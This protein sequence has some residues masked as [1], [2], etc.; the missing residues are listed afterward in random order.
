VSIP[1]D[2]FQDGRFVPDRLVKHITDNLAGYP[3][4][5]P[6]TDEGGDTTWRYHEGLG[7]FRSDGGGFIKRMADE[8]LKNRTKLNYV[9]EVLGIARIRTYMPR[10]Q[11]DEEP[12]LIILRNGVYH[13]DTGK[14]TDHSSLH[15]AKSALPVTYNPDAKCPL[16]LKFLERV[17]PTYMELLQEWT[18]YHLLKDQRHQRFVILLGDRDNGKSTY[19]HVLTSLLGPENVS[20]QSLYKLTSSRFAVAELYGKLANIAADIGPDEIKYTGALKIATGEDMGSSEKK[21]KDPFDFMSHAKLTFSCNQLPKTPDETGA[22][23]K[24]HL[25]LKFNVTIPLEEQDKTLKKKLITPEELSGILNWAL[26]GLHR[27]L[28]RGHFNEPTTIEE[29]KIQY[30]RLSNPVA[31]FA[32]DCIIEDHEEWETKG[33]IYKAFV[34]HCKTHGFVSPSD[35]LFFK[36]LKKHAY[37]R[38]GQKT[39]DKQRTTVLLGIKLMG[40]ARGAPPARGSSPKETLVYYNGGIGP[41]APHA[42]LA[43]SSETDSPPD[44]AQQALERSLIIEE[45][46]KI[47]QEEAHEVFQKTLFDKLAFRGF[48]GEEAS[49]ILR[50][51]PQFRFMG[52][53]VALKD[54]PQEEAS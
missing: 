1:D 42:P 10:E 17:A 31:T 54:L 32:E 4:I 29:R 18:G 27:L 13:I 22:F 25:V 15:F 34:Q 9:N 8:A 14:L 30:R 37:Y 5:T 11:F 53:M 7:I 49:P 51:D 52:M 35:S 44:E 36:E 16:F 46:V 3:L 43:A 2:F 21:F 28:E 41:L 26:E 24:R 45:A 40:A 19:L 20:H 50:A 48:P 12:D 38:G 33:D 23:H 39:I 47:L 6:R